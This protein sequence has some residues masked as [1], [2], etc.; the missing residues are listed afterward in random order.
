MEEK[1]GLEVVAMRN[2][3][4]RDRYS[5]VLRIAFVLALVALA[6]AAA[7]TA[8]FVLRP[9][10]QY[11]AVSP[12]GTVTKM[13]PVDQPLLA[14]SALQQWAADT[15]RMAYAIDFVHY[16]EQ[17]TNIRGRFSDAAYKAYVAQMSSSGNIKAIKENRL[18]MDAQARPAVIVGSGKIGGRYYWN[19]EVPITVTTHFGGANQRSQNMVVQMQVVRVDNRFRPESGVVV[20]SFVVSLG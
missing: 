10:P 1:G 9:Q 12:D 16:S 13:V 15:A 18:V 14:P 17:M 3:W 19:V 4:Y 2:D 7:I 6:E 8:M 11:F 20:N 5:T